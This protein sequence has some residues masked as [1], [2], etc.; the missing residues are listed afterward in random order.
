LWITPTC[1]DRGKRAF[2]DIE[3]DKLDL[4]MLRT[5]RFTNGV[6]A[7][8][9]RPRKSMSRKSGHRFCEKG[10]AQTKS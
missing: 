7:L 4:E 8:T 1:V 2:A 9:Y 5:H 10:H 6:M 3:A